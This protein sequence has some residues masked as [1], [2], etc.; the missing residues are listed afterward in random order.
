MPNNGDH[1]YLVTEDLSGKWSIV[2]LYHSP[3]VDDHGYHD[4]IERDKG[5]E[6]FNSEKEA[7]M[8]FRNVS[9]GPDL[10]DVERFTRIDPSVPLEAPLPE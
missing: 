3:S 9:N 1:H 6:G 8:Y 7:L 10:M 4:F 2:D 5:A